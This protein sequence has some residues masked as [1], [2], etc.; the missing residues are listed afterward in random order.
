MGKEVGQRFLSGSNFRFKDS[1]TFF[2]N[3]K[4]VNI[5]FSF[6]GIL[7]KIKKGK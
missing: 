3:G 7:Y 1:D 5:D 2:E 6:E 4:F